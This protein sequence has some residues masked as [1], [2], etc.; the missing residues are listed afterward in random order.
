M[1]SL[2]TTPQAW[3]ASPGHA[4]ATNGSRQPGARP[5]RQQRRERPCP[6]FSLGE[7]G[8][9]GD[10]GR[11]DVQLYF[12][13]T[14]HSLSSGLRNASS[15]GMVATMLKY[16]HGYFESAGEFTCTRYRS[17][18]RRPSSRRRAFWANMSFT[19]ISAI[20]LRTVL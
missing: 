11:S 18:I 19:S 14:E 7:A 4:P 8:A 6:D 17:F 1:K 15:A 2:I 13:K 5:A 12:L 3:N 9:R 16:S 20:F 10:A